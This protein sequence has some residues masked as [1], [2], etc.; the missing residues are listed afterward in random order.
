MLAGIRFEQ[1][2]KVGTTRRQHNFVRRERTSITGQRH[3]DE[4][5]LIPQVS[6]RR[7]DRRVEVIPTQRV[8]LLGGGVAPHRAKGRCNLYAND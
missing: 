5:F 3:V 7:Q 1:P 4:V 6:K 8:L 2:P